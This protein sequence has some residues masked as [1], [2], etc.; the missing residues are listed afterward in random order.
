[1]VEQ[2]AKEI[3]QDSAQRPRHPQH[4]GK[5]PMFPP[6]GQPGLP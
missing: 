5:F 6:S 3:E 2:L 4:S 1:M